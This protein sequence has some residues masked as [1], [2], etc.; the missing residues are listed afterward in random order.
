[1][2]S[3]QLRDGAEA[4]ALARAHADLHVE[5]RRDAGEVLDA[6]ADPDVLDR[7]I[8]AL[9]RAGIAVRLLQPCER[10]LETVFLQL[11]RAG[12]HP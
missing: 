4:S 5:R 9:G 12:A 1:M 11:T 6:A 7:Y 3:R 8:I 2:P 10:S